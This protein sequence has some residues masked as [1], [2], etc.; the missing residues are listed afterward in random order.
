M[1]VAVPSFGGEATFSLSDAVVIASGEAESRVLVSV[2]SLS[3]LQGEF[4]TSAELEF[5]LPGNTPSSSVE[6]EVSNL[7]R[8]WDA[9]ATWTSPWT[10]EGGDTDPVWGTTGELAGGRAAT[11]L[12]VDVTQMVRAIVSGDLDN[13]GFLI[14]PAAP[15]ER[16]FDSA[17][18][19]VLGDLD[20]GVLRV[21]Y[22]ELTKLYR[23]ST[24]ELDD[25]RGRAKPQ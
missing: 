10:N 24:D 9:G 8:T 1:F 7:E 3:G 23:A 18:R 6:L 2:G 19:T 13:H 14:Q 15:D 4:I 21:R 16:G 22:H 25:R 5:T 11:Q 17:G 12:T 20:G